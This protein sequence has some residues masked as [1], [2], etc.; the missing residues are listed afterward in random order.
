MDRLHV[1]VVEDSEDD[2]TLLMRSLRHAGED[3]IY[4]RVET[5]EA[6]Y[7]ALRERSWDLVITDHNMPRFSST[8]ALSVVR[9]VGID[10]L[11]RA[12]AR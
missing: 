6:M 12:E 3:P 10:E 11:S 9:E 5:P 7:S 4:E 2:V 1:L 8:A